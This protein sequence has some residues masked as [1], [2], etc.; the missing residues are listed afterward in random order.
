MATIS[1]SQFDA[2]QSMIS[3]MTG[4]LSQQQDAADAMQSMADTTRDRRNGLQEMLDD[5]T[6]EG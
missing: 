6:I 5:A 4:E 3:Q 2:V 1:Q